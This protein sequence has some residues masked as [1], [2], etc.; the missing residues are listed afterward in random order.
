M[1]RR[2]GERAGAP[3]PGDAPA[4]PAGLY[5]KMKAAPFAG[6]LDC[7]ASAVEAG[8]WQEIV[9][10]YEV[11]SS[12]VADG[13]TFKAT[14]N[15]S[16]DWA[17]FQTVDPAGAN[18]VCS[19]ESACR[20]LGSGAIA[21]ERATSRGAFRPEGARATL[22]EGRHRRCDRRLSQYGRPHRHPPRRPARR[23]AGHAGPDFVDDDFRFRAYVDPLG[24]SRS[25]PFPTSPCA[26]SR[27]R[28]RACRSS[29]RVS[30]GRAPLRL[31]PLGARPLGQ[32][33][34]RFS[35]P[36]AGL[37]SFWRRD[38]R[39]P[40]DRPSERG[41]GER[42]NRR[43]S[44][45]SRRSTSRRRARRAGRP[46]AEAFFPSSRKRR[47]PRAFYADL[48]V[49]AH[50]TVGA[51]SPSYNAAFARDI[52]GVDVFGYTANDFQITDENW[53]AASPR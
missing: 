16:S 10:D 15:F 18:Y 29:A 28:P 13:A 11:G 19:T 49:H 45:R 27:R 22:S 40:R 50:D 52:G 7:S 23:W 33:R 48:H 8:S 35:Q 26:S 4:S 47:G 21:G 6:R 24:A 46:T 3:A 2:D 34:R 51:N 37:N 20:S 9:L 17:Y 41:L 53:R 38:D 30:R 32:Y 44:D 42:R 25:S 43:H 5:E 39:R 12:G 31:P 36:R 1:H 14:F